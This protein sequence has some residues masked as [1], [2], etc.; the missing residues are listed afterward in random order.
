MINVTY[1]KQD[2]SKISVT[3]MPSSDGLFGDATTPN[4]P[5][6][7]ACLVRT[8]QCLRSQGINVSVPK[9]TEAE[10]ETAIDTQAVEGIEVSESEIEARFDEIRGFTDADVESY[11][12]ENTKVD[13]E[14]NETYKPTEEEAGLA[15]IKKV[16]NADGMDVPVEVPS[17]DEIEILIQ[18]E[19]EYAAAEA[20]VNELI[21]SGHLVT[22]LSD[23]SYDSWKAQFEVTEE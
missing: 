7:S 15:L 17:F 2:G 9:L 19:K 14:G 5:A 3:P 8:A 20:K 6:E 22:D 21:A 10:L 11:I 4:S 13:E 18:E 23:E 16:T 1:T 12:N